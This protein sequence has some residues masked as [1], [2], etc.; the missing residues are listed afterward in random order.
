MHAV[1]A[2]EGMAALDE[3]LLL[4]LFEDPDERVVTAA[5]RASEPFLGRSDRVVWSL[6]LRGFR[7]PGRADSPAFAAQ[8]VLSLGEGAC[9]DTDDALAWLLAGDPRFERVPD[10]LIQP[11][12]SDPVITELR[13]V[14]LSGLR[15]RELAF[16][17]RLV[18]SSKWSE[19]APGRPELFILLARCVVRA[20]R[21]EEIEALLG[22][23]ARAAPWQRRALV[24]GCLAGRPAGPDGKPSWIRVAQEPAALAVMPV[25][26][27]A[28]REGFQHLIDALAWPGKP[29]VT[30]LAVR[31]L[32]EAERA[33]FARGAELYATTCAACHQPSGDGE[34]GKAPRLRGSEYVLGAKERAIRILLHGM[35]GPLEI[36]GLP[37]GSSNLE[38]PA[39]SASDA[40]IAGVLTYVRREWGHG[41][42]PVSPEEVAA[43]RAATQDRKRPWTAAELG[44]GGQ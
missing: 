6:R 8:V 4:A 21:S 29:G 35:E 14:A 17:K 5:V 40:D 31:P 22:L 42:E 41:V 30:E 1:W 38:M 19:H 7:V 33:L 18:E 25:D 3:E 24:A 11:T 23:A 26:G 34:E 15:G 12:V 27:A 37:W 28:E 43:V 9:E 10:A 39:F 16:T 20:G 13:S 2:L 32:D 36:D 44:E